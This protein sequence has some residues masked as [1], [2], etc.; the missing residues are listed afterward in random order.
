MLRQNSKSDFLQE[1]YGK[2]SDELF[3]KAIAWRESAKKSGARKI[4]LKKGH[5]YRRKEFRR[6]SRH[7]SEAYDLLLMLDIQ[8]RCTDVLALGALEYITKDQDEVDRFPRLALMSLLSYLSQT[9][10]SFRR[11]IINE[12][13][14]GARIISRSIAEASDYMLSMTYDSNLA[15]QY[16][17][18]NE[19]FKKLWTDKLRTKEL[20]KLRKKA[21]SVFF[22]EGEKVVDEV[23]SFINQEILNA[24]KSVHPTYEAGVMHFFDFMDSDPNDQVWGFL[25]RWPHSRA[26]RFVLSYATLPVVITCIAS[27][28]EERRE[29]LKLKI[30]KDSFFGFDR[31][32]LISI[33]QGC[34]LASSFSAHHATKFVWPS[35][36]S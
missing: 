7:G 3:E 17:E 1:Y 19:N 18:A 24:S 36:G 32:A 26:A 21:L 30:P 2:C 9:L 23:C 20:S 6:F 27:I 14:L 13:D 16:V 15:Q 11:E 8:Q 34:L 12:C 29:T 31:P 33:I 22:G 4:L 10:G 35:S 25:S 28:D 5:E